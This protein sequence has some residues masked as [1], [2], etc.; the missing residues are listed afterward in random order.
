MTCQK[1]LINRRSLVKGIAT[2]GLAAPFINFLVKPARAAGTGVVNFA[3][4]GG[5]FNTALREIWFDEFEKET[6][7]KVNL[8][9]GA[10]LALAK[11]QVMNP[12]GAEW[13]IID[14]TADGYINAVKEDLLLPV[15]GRIDFSKI[16]PEYVG[17]HGWSYVAFIYVIGWN[18][19][20]ISDADA[21]KHWVDVW[22]T[23]RYKGKRAL[24]NVNGQAYSLEAALMADGVLPKEMY[25]LDLNRSFASLEKLGRDNIVW[26]VS[27]QDAVQQ[28]GS[29]GTPLG[30]TA[31]GRAI[32][33]RR[34]GADISFSLEQG[35]IGSDSLGVIKNSNNSKEAFQLLNFITTRG[36]LSAKFTERTAYGIPHVDVESLLSPDAADIRAAL[37][38]NPTLRKTALMTDPIYYETHMP[39]VITRFQEWQLK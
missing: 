22:D 34:Q 33:A 15:D 27:L 32:I 18:N 3:G 10:S 1:S 14:L 6:G 35:I 26:G 36:D 30:G 12:A 37:P 25:P 4:Y 31:S 16:L 21:P 23:K 8:G 9:S 2:A 29:G 13:D 7:I 38:S 11:L 28:L 5:S 24:Y 17:T 19:K 39:E 20:L